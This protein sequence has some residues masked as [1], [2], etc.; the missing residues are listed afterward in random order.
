VT[1]RRVHA[2]RV[3]ATPGEGPHTGVLLQDGTTA[4]KGS[5]APGVPT[6]EAARR[7]GDARVGLA[8]AVVVM[9]GPRGSV[10]RGTLTAAHVS[11]VRMGTG[12]LGRVPDPEILR[13]AIAR[14]A[15]APLVV[16]P[17]ARVRRARLVVTG[18][19]VR[20]VRSVVVTVRP[21]VALV[22]T[23][24]TALVRRAIVRQAD[25]LVVTVRTPLVRTVIA[26]AVGG[27]AVTVP[28]TVAPAATV[29]RA[30]ARAP[31]AP[32]PMVPTAVRG[33]AVMPVTVAVSG[34]T[35]IRWVFAPS[36]LASS[37]RTCPTR[38]N[39]ASSTRSLGPSSRP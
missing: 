16:G 22:V 4:G 36:A 33:A 23:V 31:V 39:R 26:P 25:A 11:S 32:A 2:L 21:G 28:T 3:Q 20:S 34:R 29:R 7:A 13:R 15:L 12:P 14:G 37:S 6:V 9:T 10:G 8:R 27:P 1:A 5:V 24:P 38:S 35:G 18:P 19:L 30:D 17:T